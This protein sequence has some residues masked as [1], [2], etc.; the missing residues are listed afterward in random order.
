MVVPGLSLLE[1]WRLGQMSAGLG[2]VRWLCD[3]G[4][5]CESGLGKQGRLPVPKEMLKLRIGC[6][7]GRSLGR[8]RKTL[9]PWGR[10][11]SFRDQGQRQFWGKGP[12]TP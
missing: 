6:N 9:E 3:W 10:G 12:L 2:E 4:I 7:C 5:S 8:A 11:S 1:G